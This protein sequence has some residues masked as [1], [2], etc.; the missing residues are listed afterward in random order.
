MYWELLF[1]SNRFSLKELSLDMALTQRF[2]FESEKTSTLG[3]FIKPLTQ[4]LNG[5]IEHL[6][7]PNGGRPVGVSI[8][9]RFL[10]TFT[11]RTAGVDRPDEPHGH[12]PSH[13]R[14]GAGQ[15]SRR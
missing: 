10:N 6:F 14:I 7:V 13:L 9:A 5:V 3:L 12:A 1:L 15:Q 2:G 11:E 4:L 8:N